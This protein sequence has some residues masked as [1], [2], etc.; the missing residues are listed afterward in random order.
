MGRRHRLDASYVYQRLR[1]VHYNRVSA[2]LAD[3][4][5]KRG[6]RVENGHRTISGGHTRTVY[7]QVMK[8]VL[9]WVITPNDLDYNS[10]SFLFYFRFV[11]F[12]KRTDTNEARIR[13]FCMTDDREDKTLEHKEHFTEV[14]NS[15]DVEVCCVYINNMADINDWEKK[16]WT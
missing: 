4:L 3:G 6:G 7:G 16:K 12:A 13:L 1:I 9:F 10:Y 14:S 5:Q 8:T 11:V 2:I 15:R